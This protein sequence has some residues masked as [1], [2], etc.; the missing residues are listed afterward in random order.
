MREL[1]LKGVPTRRLP[2]GAKVNQVISSDLVSRNFKR[3]RPDDLWMT[4]IERHEALLNR[5][6][7]KGH[8]YQ[9]VVA[10]W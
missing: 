9:L 10:G 5:V 8:R 4:D 3:D 7:M 2:K 6:V 1:G